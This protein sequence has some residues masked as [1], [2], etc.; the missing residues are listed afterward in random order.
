MAAPKYLKLA[1]GRKQEATL[2]AQDLA[3]TLGYTPA[4]QT[5]FTDALDPTGFLDNENIAVSYDSSAR[6]ITLT[7]VG[8]INYYWRGTKYTLASPWTSSAHTATT[9]IWYLATTDGTTFAWSQTA[10]AFSDMQVAWVWYGS[11]D[12]FAMREVH[13]T[14]PWQAHD[15]LHDTVG[16]YRESGL[17]L[18]GATYVVGGTPTDAA[19]TPGVLG[20]AIHDEDCETAIAAWSQ[21]T[22]TQ[23][24]FSGSDTGNFDTTATSLIRKGTN[25]PYINNWSGSAWSDVEMLTGRFANVYLLYV[26]AAADSNSQKYRQLVLQPQYSYSTLASAQGE[27][28]TSLRLTGIAAI[29]PESVIYGRITI[30]TSASWA[31]VFGRFRIVAVSYIAGSKIT[32]TSVTLP[33]PASEQIPFT[34]AG[35]IAATNVRDALIELDTEK[36]A[37]NQSLGSENA[38]LTLDG[39]KN[40]YLA[41]AA[42]LSAEGYLRLGSA[43]KTDPAYPLHVESVGTDYAAVTTGSELFAFYSGSW[44]WTLG[45]GWTGNNTD[46]FAHSSGT[47]TLTC[48]VDT[49]PSGTTVY[50]LAITVTGRTTGSFTFAFAGISRPS[51]SATTYFSLYGMGT[52]TL[53]VTP[54]TGFD[55][56]LKFTLYA[57]SPSVPQARIGNTDYHEAPSAVSTVIGGNC[58]LNL[59]P[60]RSSANTFVGQS[61]GLNLSSAV[62][63]TLVG[64]YSARYAGH[65]EN[66][67]A[68]GYVNFETADFIVNAVAIGYLAGRYASGNG[69]IAVGYNVGSS[70]TG[71]YNIGIGYAALSNAVTGQKNI[72]IGYDAE[73]PSNS[74]DNQTNIGDQIYCWNTGAS[75]RVRIGSTSDDGANM[76]QVPGNIKAS[77]YLGIEG[78]ATWDSGSISANSYTSTT[79]TATGAALGDFVLVSASAALDTGTM[80]TAE[81][82]SSNTVTVKLYNMTASPID[83]SSKTYYVRVLAK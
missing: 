64:A 39:S 24:W 35:N 77:K 67:A 40:I 21:G 29:T 18:D 4:S 63:S 17:T 37:I 3:D 69:L 75:T 47:A 68:L 11:S 79:I 66:C 65:V 10:W 41:S 56:T 81:V 74:A 82:T 36:L 43:I 57:V 55:G 52:A 60:G 6:T 22:Y 83:P 51:L 7:R 49:P 30:E 20:G 32:Q 54:T 72:A 46:G 78:S 38:I 50:N 76:L 70:S 12:K 45:S 13:G 61:C 48:S 14:M 8:G 15:I 16:C 59:L 9:G 28:V 25:Y 31:G 1:S 2:S 33:I 23:L 71:D 53:T 34:P 44:T 58:G 19:N 80:M 73:V 62:T 42:A 26:P 5:I 27:A